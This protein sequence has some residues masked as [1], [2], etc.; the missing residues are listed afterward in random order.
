MAF[1]AL[2]EAVIATDEPHKLL[3]E[4]GQDPDEAERLLRLSPAKMGVELGKR[5]GGGAPAR[6]R[7]TGAPKPITP[8]SQ[9]GRSHDPIA[10]SDPERADRLSTEAWMKRR[11]EELASKTAR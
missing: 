7:A 4:L 2:V 1:R 5:L 3:F 11:E 8:I 9:R 6:P 10:A